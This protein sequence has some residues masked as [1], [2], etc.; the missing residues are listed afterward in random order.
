MYKCFVLILLIISGAL[1]AED[2]NIEEFSKPDK[3]GWNSLEE[4]FTA[5]QDI[6]KRQELLQ[7]YK[8]NKQSITVNIIKSAVA[9]GWGHYSTKD[10][11]K[12]HIFISSEIIL[13]CTSYYFYNRSMDEY[14]KYK[15][16]HYIADIEQSFIDA[17]N[18]Y[19]YSQLFLSLGTI[20]WLYTIYDS[21]NSTEE[22]NQNLWDSLSKR[23]YSKKLIITPIGITWKF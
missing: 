22:Y 18:N 12:G 3:Y 7:I 10:Y 23:V 20:V 17:N 11:T 14:D 4:R 8:M 9:P 2:F 13:L 16:S 21:I 5:R 1:S 19:K 6:N 15:N